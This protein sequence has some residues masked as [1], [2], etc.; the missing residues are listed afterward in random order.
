MEVILPVVYWL[1]RYIDVDITQEGYVGVAAELADRIYNHICI[2]RNNTHNNKQL[3]ELILSGELV[4]TILFYGSYQDCFN[5]EKRLRP[6]KHIGLN[7]AAGGKGGPNTLGMKMSEEF[8]QKRREYMMG[9]TIATGNRG[10][11]KSAAHRRRI[12]QALTGKIVSD[13]QKRKQSEAMSGRK[14]TEEH[15]RKIASRLKGRKRRQSCK[16]DQSMDV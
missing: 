14:L 2:A 9:N 15:R 6:R 7:I 16:K 4:V 5:R 13:E 1:H 3:Q 12:G 8:K 11:P 10:K